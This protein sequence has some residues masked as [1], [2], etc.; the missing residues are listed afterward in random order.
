M[1]AFAAQSG[2]AHGFAWT[3]DL[4]GVNGKGLDLRLRLPDWI[5]GGLEQAA[6][7]VVQTRVARGNLT[8]G[9]KIARAGTSAAGVQLDE[10]ALEAVLIQIAHVEKAAKE[11]GL[12]LTRPSA[13]DIL[14]RP[15]VAGA[16]GPE[17]DTVAL[18]AALTA[19]LAPLLDAF[20][21]MRAGEGAALRA[22]LSDQLATISELTELA[23]A[24]AEARRDQMADAMRANLVR[25]LDNSEGADP[26]RVAQELALI[27]VKSDVR[28]EIDRLHAHVEAASQLLNAEGPVG[29]KLDFLMQEFNREANTLCSKAQSN[30]LTRIGLDLKHVI[31]Q[32]REQV[33]NVE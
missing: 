31:D 22:A 3:W 28:E 24:E 4:R 12:E 8:L 11:Q 7:A 32:M 1:T 15:G 9:L 27:A 33:Q 14:S 17:A 5:G 19:D 2:E 13:L 20:V 26:D 25:V 29:R 18:V 16:A 30:A 21:A 6:R 10:N 23:A